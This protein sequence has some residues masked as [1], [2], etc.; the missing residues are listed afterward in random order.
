VL[1]GRAPVEESR[2]PFHVAAQ[3]VSSVAK[4]PGYD[5]EGF[6]TQMRDVSDETRVRLRERFL[7]LQAERRAQPQSHAPP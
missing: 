1:E 5:V 4:V 7:P 3:A 2:T 6:I